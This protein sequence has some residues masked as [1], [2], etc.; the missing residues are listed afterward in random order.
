MNKRLI[1][2]LISGCLLYV[3]IELSSFLGLYLLKTYRHV[4]YAP[5]PS[6][7]LSERHQ[8]IIEGFLQERTRYTDYSATLGWTIKKNGIAPLY[9]ANSQGIRGNHK[10]ARQAP[11]DMI[12]IST[13]GDS[14]THC[15]D[16][17]NH[18]TWQVQ[19]QQ[20]NPD[21][22]V[23][24]FGVGGFGLDQAFLRYQEKIG[25]FDSQIVLIGYMTENIFRHVNVFRPFYLSA[26]GTPLTK[27]R[28]A[29]RNEE[30]ILID[31]PMRQ[32]SQYRELL[33][34]PETT[35]P[36]LGKHDHHFN[37]IYKSSMFDFLPSYRLL[38]ILSYLYFNSRD[39]IT[40]GYY[41]TKSE[42]YRVTTRLLDK[43]YQTVQADGSQPV[44]LIF[45]EPADIIR[46]RENGTR[47]YAPLVA[48]LDEKKYRY[49]DLLQA[50]DG[51]G[52][53]LATNKLFAKPSLNHYSPLANN[54]AAQIIQ[55]YLRKEGLLPDRVG[56]R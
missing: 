12:R 53:Q 3:A 37:T 44:I 9:R 19:L 22:E 27:P 18:E 5:P 14:Y 34:S 39:V 36:A 54:L 2:W 17:A 32:L 28:F 41:N 56:P 31:N 11:E 6:I 8:Q 42:A 38:N 23:L 47:Q 55:Q 13:Y 20:L 52:G 46:Y 49:I 15:D 1:F 43:F 26:T 24:N 16:V 25:Q 48:Y 45:P 50:L 33:E 40:D 29:L 4:E 51:I 21:L 10:Y 30:L 7:S 35:L